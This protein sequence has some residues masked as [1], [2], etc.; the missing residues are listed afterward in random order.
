MAK[1]LCCD[2]HHVADGP[3]IDLLLLVL[4]ER[5]YERESY[6]SWLAIS[7]ALVSTG[8]RSHIQHIQAVSLT[9]THMFRLNRL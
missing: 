4:L 1:Y 5:A 3:E 9:Y 6:G 7:A 8:L 2:L